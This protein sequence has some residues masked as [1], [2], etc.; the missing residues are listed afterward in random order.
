MVI[1]GVRAIEF[2]RRSRF[3]AY[4]HFLP[5]AS[6]SPGY[7]RVPRPRQTTARMSRPGTPSRKHSEQQRLS[8][9]TER[10]E[11]PSDEATKIER[12]GVRSDLGSSVATMPCRYTMER[13]LAAGH[14]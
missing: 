7:K 8:A 14:V 12:Y 11:S 2:I 4:H 9:I 1:E 10:A 5:S 13:L 3:L 6:H